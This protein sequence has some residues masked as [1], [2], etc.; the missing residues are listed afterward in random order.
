ME[1]EIWGT[2]A[3]VGSLSVYDN[4]IIIPCLSCLTGREDASFRD[5][6]KII[7]M[8]E[9]WWEIGQSGVVGLK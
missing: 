1:P 9:L 7:G 2:R 6:F 4:T 5:I 3:D 8:G